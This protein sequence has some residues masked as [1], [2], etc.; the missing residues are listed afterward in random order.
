M[1]TNNQSHEQNLNKAHSMKNNIYHIYPNNPYAF[2]STIKNKNLN[3][4]ENKANMQLTIY[5]ESAGAE[6]TLT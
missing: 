5:I 3:N 2:T 6:T 4:D 1:S